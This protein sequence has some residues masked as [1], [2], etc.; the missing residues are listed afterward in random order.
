MNFFFLLGILKATFLPF[1]NSRGTKHRLLRGFTQ[2]HEQ[3]L[4]LVPNPTHSRYQS[5]FF[6]LFISVFLNIKLMTDE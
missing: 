5:L 4:N 1:F 6:L 3:Y 2:E